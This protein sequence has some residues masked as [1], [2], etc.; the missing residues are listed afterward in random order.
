MVQIHWLRFLIIIFSKILFNSLVSSNLF[1]KF[2]GLIG[3]LN[4]IL[5][6]SFLSL[7]IN[8]GIIL[9]LNLLESWV[10]MQL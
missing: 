3:F 10:G 4:S 6:L 9:R 1:L 7:L 5:K 8:T 2:S